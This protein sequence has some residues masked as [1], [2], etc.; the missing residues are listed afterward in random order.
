[1]TTFLIFFII[2]THGTFSCRSRFGNL[3]SPHVIPAELVPAKAGSGNLVI[4]KNLIKIVL[5]SHFRGND[6]V[7]WI[8][9][10]AGTGWIPAAACARESGYWNDG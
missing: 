3:V 4:K 6:R 8:P 10:S 1:M 2:L 7:S 9:A 5:D